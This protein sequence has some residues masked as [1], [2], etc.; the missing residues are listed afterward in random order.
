MAYAKVKM[1][2]PVV[3]G[4]ILT[5]T[6]NEAD[7]LMEFLGATN[8]TVVKELLDWAGKDY[9]RDVNCALYEVFEALS[10]AKVKDRVYE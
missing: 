8:I 10:S 1:S 6:E 3:E 2:E 5:L 7:L 9:Q 4:V